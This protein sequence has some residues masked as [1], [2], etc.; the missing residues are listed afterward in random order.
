MFGPKS[1]DQVDKDWKGD[2]GRNGFLLCRQRPQWGNPRIHAAFKN[3]WS[4][5]SLRNDSFDF[6]P[7]F[8]LL[9][10]MRGK[11]Q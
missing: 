3:I 6:I 8:F 7:F 5:S 1:L 4:L 2:I 9:L 11:Y 10:T